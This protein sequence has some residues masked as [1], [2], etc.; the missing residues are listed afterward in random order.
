MDF[1]MDFSKIFKKKQ[2]QKGKKRLGIVDM[3]DKLTLSFD[4]FIILG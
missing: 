2:I 4:A 1:Q 3:H